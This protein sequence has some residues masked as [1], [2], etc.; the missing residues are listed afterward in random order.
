MGTFDHVQPGQPGHISADAYNAAMDAARAH[1]QAGPLAG[2]GAAL[3]S[4]DHDVIWVRNNTGS[5]LAQFSA[6]ALGTPI[7]VPGDNES[8]WKQRVTFEAGTPAVGDRGE[9]AVVIERIPA[10]KIG[11]A[12]KNGVVQCKVNVLNANDQ[13]AD[14][15]P[16]QTYLTS[17][18][19]SVSYTH[20]T[21]PTN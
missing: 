8:E 15:T 12:V 2:H 11:R 20:L 5:A 19:G 18:R 7:I 21:L 1:R 17:T 13:Y 14:L 3:A 9:V 16:S 10:G 4:A 6:V